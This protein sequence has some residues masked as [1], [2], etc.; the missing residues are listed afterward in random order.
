MIKSVHRQRVLSLRQIETQTEY[1]SDSHDLIRDFYIP[2]LEK[3]VIYN[4]AV[5]FF[6][7]SSMA[8]VARGLSAFIGTGGHMRLVTSPKLS[9]HDIEAIA[10]GLQGRDQVIERALLREL[11][12]DLEQVLKDRLACLAWLLSQGVFDIKLAIPKSSR[13]WG[14]YHEK[15]GV[16]EDGDRNYIAFTGSANESSSALIDNFECLDVFTS[17]DERV[18]D[19]AQKKR[20]NFQRLWDDET[21]NIE[22]LSFPEAAAKS[23]LRFCPQSAPAWEPGLSKPIK[24][25]DPSQGEY[26]G[27]PGSGSDPGPTPSFLKVSLRPRQI[28]ALQAWQDANGRGILAMAT[29]TGKTITALGAATSL[30]DL[31]LVVIAAPTNEIV[32]QWISELEARTNFHAPIVATGRAEA[33]REPLFRKLRLLKHGRF[34]QEKQPI[35]VIGSYGEMSRETTL[36]LIDNVDGLPD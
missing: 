9:P 1:R 16:F 3:A 11:E 10:R 20:D 2:C 4:R 36:Q 5:G 32:Q 34:P 21:P 33:W 30:K 18:Q 12:H 13:Q 25:R 35:I 31:E 27:E 14:I 22:I 17:W 7:S 26:N 29:G 19:R 15:L 23:L 8:A 6:S 28:D 24:A